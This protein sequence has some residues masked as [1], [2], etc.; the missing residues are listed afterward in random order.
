M[1]KFIVIAAT[2]FM[3]IPVFAYYTTNGKDIVDRK[4]GER[5]ILRGIGLGG[6]LLPEGY[7]WGTRVPDRPWQFEKAIIDL[8]GQE[9]AEEFW[10]IYHD[11]FVTEHDFAAMKMWG[12]NTVRIPLLASKLQP[13]DGQPDSA[14]YLY[15]E[16]GFRFLDSVVK[17]SG[18]YHIGVIWDLHGAPG[19]QSKENI[20][21]SDGEARLWSEKDK[22]FPMCADL[23]R[24]IAERYKNNECIVGYDLLNEPLLRRYPEIDQ[25]LLRKLYVLLTNEIRE[26]DKEGI[27]FIE[28]DE[29][30][31]EFEI[32]E[33]INWDK[34]LVIAFHSYPPTSTIDGLK[35][36]DTF[37]QKYNIPLWHGETG[38][39]RAPY[40]INIASTSL[41]EQENVGW[42]WWTH[43]KF[44][45]TSQPWSIIATEGFRNIL[46]Y[47]RGRAPRPNAEDA[48]KWLFDQARLTNT[49]YCVFLPDMVKSLVPLD[50]ESYLASLEDFFP[51]ILLQPREVNTYTGMPA[52]FEII[53]V[54]NNL[55][56]QWNKNNIPIE[57]ATGNELKYIVS[58][59]DTLAYFSATVQNRLG[60]ITSLAVPLNII[61]YIGPILKETASAP[62]IDGKI[63]KCWDNVQKCEIDKAVYGKAE[64]E[65]DFG[66]YFKTMYDQKNLYF[67]VE[68][69]DDSIVNSNR[70]RFQNDGVEIY[71]DTDNNRPK[72]YTQEEFIV[73]IVPGRNDIFIDRGKRDAIFSMKQTIAP[74]GYV[75]ELALPWDEVGKLSS[76]YIGLDVQINDTDSTTRKTKLSWANTRDDANSS[77]RNL[78]AIKTAK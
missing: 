12:L 40:T 6:W 26:V 44:D 60:N 42:A 35:R 29:W 61:P 34:H 70:S 43:K 27:I 65:K 77:P 24:K 13:R 57:G 20:A 7:M 41:L 38:E 15:S 22:Y 47:W 50:P 19:A 5:V 16:E 51:E 11:N 53:A 14:P 4:T 72:Y 71:L 56:I 68:V 32:L 54:G 37:R 33:P 63:D 48:E 46:D 30:A 64:C 66:G 74:K 3:F 73:R 23:W 31:Q 17:W 59:G 21:D 2:L 69:T 55:N 10:R 58:P 18:K 76:A 75:V 49:K 52:Y 36:W 62:I 25:S 28:G 39:Q 78:G 67:L 45:N 9:K 1:K 8:I